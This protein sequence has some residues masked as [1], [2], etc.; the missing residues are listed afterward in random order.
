MRPRTTS[1]IR[2]RSPVWSSGPSPEAHPSPAISSEAGY[3]KP[4]REVY[5]AA[6]ARAGITAH[7]AMHIGD[8][9]HLDFV[10]AA[11]LGMAAMLIDRERQQAAP[12][13]TGRTARIRSLALVPEV[14]RVLELE[15]T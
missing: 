4:R 1:E 10:P 5:D 2:T 15:L 14:A 13:I 7:E 6:L 11:A 3:A 12:L 9:E 8:S